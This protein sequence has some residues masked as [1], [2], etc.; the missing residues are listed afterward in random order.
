[1]RILH[2]DTER[3]WRGGEQQA[4]YL[5][6]GLIE[7]GHEAHALAQ[8]QCPFAERARKAGVPVIEMRMRG[9]ADPIAIIRIARLMR[10]E[11][12]DIAH[13]HTSHAHTLGV[14]AAALSWTGIRRI[15]SRRVDFSIHKLPLRVSGLKYKWGVDRYVSVSD[16][17][18]S[19]L[20]QDGIPPEKITTVHSCNDPA[21]FDGV[22]AEGLRKEFGISPD[23]RIIGNVAFLVDHKGQIF[24]VD[25]LPEVLE[26]FP[27][28]V[29]FIIG[30]GELREPLE[31]RVRELGIQGHVIFAG[32]R[33]DALR[34]YKLFEIF[35]ISSHMEG[36]CTSVQEAFALG[37][38]VVVT[39][40]GGLPEMVTN[41][42][43]GIV[44]EK[45]NPAAFA[46][47]IIRMLSDQELQRR[48]AEAGRRTFLERFTVDR[49]VEG[50]LAVYKDVLG[51]PP[52]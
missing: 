8:P 47:G 25:A 46:A 43:N 36:L 7:R 42:E 1:M 44:V 28:L 38:P 3:T 19:V 39:N 2:I 23:A 30:E 6:K 18:R 31:A 11:R 32:F 51:D 9:E 49:M 10:K 20:I 15:V 41:G 4:L 24:L 40:A 34:F 45:R 17:I 52:E 37:T 48:C 33:S 5:M 12:Y 50:T 13:M 22:S 16:F 27:E 14:A 21:R 29:C 35:V 26:R